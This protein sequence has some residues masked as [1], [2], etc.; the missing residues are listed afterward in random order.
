[1]TCEAGGL[2][3]HA[4]ESLMD[5]RVV[6]VPTPAISRYGVSRF[7]LDGEQWILVLRARGCWP[8]RCAR[9]ALSKS[10]MQGGLG[11]FE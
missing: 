9:L 4:L 11:L 8:M 3:L 2:Y 1:M 5:A 10:P 7:V 6:T